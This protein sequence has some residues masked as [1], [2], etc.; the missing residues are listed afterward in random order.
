M[1][2]LT[3][4]HTERVDD[5]P[6]LLHQMQKLGLA[7]IINNHLKPHGNRQG[8][9]YGNIACVWLAHILSQADHCM[10]HLRAWVD[11][12]KNTVQAFLPHQIKDTDFTDDRLAD[13]LQAFSD[14]NSWEEI[15]QERNQ[16]TLT[17]YELP[18]QVVRLDVTTVSVQTQPGEL[19]R[20]GHS[21]DHRPEVPQVKVMMAT[22]SHD[23]HSKS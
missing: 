5:I 19:F 10:S 23:G 15:Q 16:H 21:K 14:Q 7:Q 12:R 22:Q 6:L 3:S 4:F 13:L 8:L 20:C 2:K 11:T 17:I 1:N 9:S 18:T